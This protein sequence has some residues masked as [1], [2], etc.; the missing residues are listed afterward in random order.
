MC[1]RGTLRYPDGKT[2]TGQF[3][4]DKKEGNGVMIWP[5]GC[6]YMV[7]IIPFR[8]HGEMENSM[9]EVYSGTKMECKPNNYGKMEDRFN[10][11]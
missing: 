6:Q 2:Y 5:N 3:F 10:E 4:N 9:E 11:Y 7:I 8:D 1:G